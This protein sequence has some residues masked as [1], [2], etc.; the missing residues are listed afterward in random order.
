M[1]WK[2]EDGENFKLI[3]YCPVPDSFDHY[4]FTIGTVLPNS[5]VLAFM[6]NNSTLTIF[7]MEY[8]QLVEE[9]DLQQEI[10]EITSSQNYL[11]VE[12][13]DFIEIFSWTNS[14]L[15]LIFKVYTGF[16]YS[17][18]SQNDIASYTTIVDYNTV[19]LQNV[20]TN[21]TIAQFNA[22]YKVYKSVITAD[23][24]KAAALEFAGTRYS[25]FNVGSNEMLYQ[26]RTNVCLSG[27]SVIS[28]DGRSMYFTSPNMIHYHDFNVENSKK[29]IFT[30][31]LANCNCCMYPRFRKINDI[32]YFQCIDGSGVLKLY[33]L[34]VQNKTWDLLK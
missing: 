12:I 13:S 24:S 22:G 2:N 19:I 17:D 20:T 11:F 16:A 14:K 21:E 8:C 1:F 27:R 6:R 4:L 10:T 9:R 29:L 3:G 33:K 7:D 28:D 30:Y 23:A 18:I 32:E 34:N 5:S 31:K 15:K 25:I 26:G